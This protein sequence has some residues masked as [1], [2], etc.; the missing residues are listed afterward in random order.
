[1]ALRLG[2]PQMGSGDWNP[3]IILQ[4]GLKYFSWQNV[5]SMYVN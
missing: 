1:M 5:R 3:G 2:N 4:R